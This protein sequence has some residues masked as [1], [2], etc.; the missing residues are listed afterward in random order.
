MRPSF[1]VSNSPSNEDAM[2][3]RP[4]RLAVKPRTTDRP[5]RCTC[6]TSAYC[7]VHG[8]YTPPQ[9]DED[10]VTILCNEAHVGGGQRIIRKT[11][12]S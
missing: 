4:R 6:D 12:E 10:V 8:E 5:G 1:P 3:V 7:P 11:L 9:Y 2:S